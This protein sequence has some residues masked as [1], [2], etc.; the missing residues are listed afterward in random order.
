MA[1]Y[2][3]GIRA[4][5]RYHYYFLQLTPLTIDANQDWT[6]EDPDLYAPSLNPEEMS[7]ASTMSFSQNFA[8]ILTPACAIIYL[9]N[10]QG[11]LKTHVRW[12]WLV[13]NT[14]AAKASANVD[15]LIEYFDAI[16][17]EDLRLLTEV[18]KRIQSLGYVQGRLSPT[19][20]MGT[21]LFQKLIMQA[22]CQS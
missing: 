15:P 4:E 16:Q 17:Q 14:E 6:R 10:P 8:W 11:P 7:W 22:I 9:V 13:P 2:Y 18:Q 21:H 19:R 12:D 20:E 1:K 3:Q 5:A